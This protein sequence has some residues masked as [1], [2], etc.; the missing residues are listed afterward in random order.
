MNGSEEPL[1]HVCSAPADEAWVSGYLLP[2]LNL[3]AG[4]FH[5][6][7]EDR[8]GHPMVT[9][10][11]EA[12]TR[13]RFTLLVLSR[14]FLANEWSEYAASLASHQAIRQG[15]LLLVSR[16]PCELPLHI[17]FRVRLELFDGESWDEPVAR[18]RAVL[19]RPE[20]P[21]D[22]MIPCPYPGLAPF[23]TADGGL[24]FGRD[25]EIEELHARLSKPELERGCQIF[26]IGPSGSGKSSLLRAGLVPG[27]ARD[28]GD[29]TKPHYTL[30]HVRPGDRPMTALAA[31]LRQT[32]DQRPVEAIAALLE[33]TPARERVLLLV[34]PLEE[35][36]TLASDSDAE[37]FLATISALREQPRCAVV[38]LMR[39]DFYP[40]L[41]A[42]SLW[43][44]GEERR[45]DLGPLREEALRKAIRHPADARGVYVEPALLERLAHEASHGVG[46]LPLLQETLVLLWKRRCDRGERRLLTLASYEGLSRPDD[47]SAIKWSALQV[48]LSRHADHV[49]AGLPDGGESVAR[50][51][52][53]RLVHLGD[54]GPDT[55]RQQ[56]EAALRAAGDD[57]DRFEE[58]L[59]RLADGRLVTL[60]A[61]PVAGSQRLVDLAHDSLITGWPRLATW[62]HQLREHEQRRRR[63]EEKALDWLRLGGRRGGL[64]DREQLPEFESWMTSDTVLHLGTDPTLKS[65]VGA[66]RAALRRR[67][68][69]SYAAVLSLLAFTAAVSVLA[70]LLMRQRGVTERSL[71]AAL[72]VAEEVTFTID[73]ELR[74]V[75]GASKVRK[76]LLARARQLVEG[77]EQLVGDSADVGRARAVALAHQADLLAEQGRHA[78][79]LSLYQQAHTHFGALAYR[80]PNNT[81]WQRNLSVS[82]N[83][84]GDIYAALGK[85]TEALLSFQ[86]ALAIRRKLVES[87]PDNIAWQGDLARSYA[88]LGDAYEA[89]GDLT[90]AGFSLQNALA[91]SKKLAEREPDDID[92]QRD[93][94]MSYRK[95]GD[96]DRTIGR[97]PDALISFQDA[98]AISKRLA[99][100]DPD[101]SDW[102]WDLSMSYGRIGDIHQRTN[103]LPEALLS[104]EKAFVI[105]KM[106][107]EREPDNLAWQSDLAMSYRKLG[108][109]H[110]DT[111]HLPEALRSFQD[112]LAIS[113]GL[114]D[115]EPDKITWQ[116]DLAMSYRRLGDIHQATGKLPEALRSFRASLAISKRLAERQPHEP[117][118]QLYLFI[119]YNKLGRAYAVTS[120]LLNATRSFQ[121]ALAVIKEL[122]ASAP[123]NTEWQRDL[124]VLYVELGD[125][126]QVTGNLPEALRCYQAALAVRKELADREPQN[127]A[128]QEGL[129]AVHLRLADLAIVRHRPREARVHVRSA[130]AI[131]H[132]LDVDKGLRV[133]TRLAGLRSY[134]ARVRRRV[135]SQ[136]F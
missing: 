74:T 88:R 136:S 86:D 124:S 73:R 8:P 11:A 103:N 106:L 126:Y 7:R 16:E 46:V 129:V 68:R 50:R 43:P 79:A 30:C 39:A 134:L 101:N 1:L 52:L 111:S 105:S 92:W 75:A 90:Q 72:G 65:F 108:D 45:F 87:E 63:L 32:P 59:R 81:T 53:V 84:I 47:V 110:Q 56:P 5:T 69:W 34:D 12:T 6:R 83:R 114:A 102:Q 14:A 4:Q 44:I 64:L 76:R 104:S 95:L 67:T 13:C 33:G 115:R 119:S 130:T 123:D 38:A 51:I 117:G 121:D 120:E 127:E 70:L 20:P 112:A 128:W 61:A 18:L 57:P 89:I 113:R 77:L 91:I 58:V 2:A 116:R 133:D 93:L 96:L 19:W 31:A 27:L 94:A 37:E 3:G 54:S 22:D 107:A 41:M 15:K 28:E 100:Q 71:T 17:D 80:S 97:L 10:I 85:P 29:P 48:A 25:K 26:L 82:H 125:V 135:K 98:L 55:R 21:P 42:S 78:E 24:F 66:S 131:L 23:E 60:I 99:E 36:F 35:I 62:L 118:W 49:L 9:E 122:S 40:Q 132:V 109:I